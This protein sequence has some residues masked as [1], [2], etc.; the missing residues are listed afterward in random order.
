M[1]RELDALL[2]LSHQAFVGKYGREIDEL[3]GLS[4]EEIDEIT[5]DLTDLEIYDRL[6]SVVKLAS[7]NNISQAELGKRIRAL[8]EVAVRIVKKTKGLYNLLG[9]I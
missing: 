2:A 1:E 8:G 6:L 4:R 7:K 3:L 9:D 5:P